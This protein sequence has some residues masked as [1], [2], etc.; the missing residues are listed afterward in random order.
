MS[1]EGRDQ[2]KEKEMGPGEGLDDVEF[3]VGRKFEQFFVHAGWFTGTVTAVRSHKTRF[4][5][6][7]E[8]QH[9]PAIFSVNKLTWIT[10]QPKMGENKISFV[11]KF[12]GNVVFNGRIE[13]ITP[14][15]HYECHYDG[16]GISR[17]T[18]LLI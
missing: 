9:R 15:G 8:I 14:C 12:R 18:P 1:E 3:G 5:K 10:V 4:V 17:H 16:G 11:C 6:F 7:D 2:V 13:E